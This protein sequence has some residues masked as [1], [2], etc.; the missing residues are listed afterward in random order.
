MYG[1]QKKVSSDPEQDGYH[2]L[3]IKNWYSVK[4][5]VTNLAGD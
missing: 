5:I 1:K 3:Q 2:Q 4:Y